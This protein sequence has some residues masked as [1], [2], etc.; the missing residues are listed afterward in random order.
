MQWDGR[1]FDPVHQTQ[2]WS[3]LDGPWIKFG[4]F[5]RAMDFFGN[6][7]LWII[8]APGHMPGNLCAAAHVGEDKWILLGSDCCHSRFVFLVADKCAGR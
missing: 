6:G 4:A 2:K 5:D 3:E 8:Q 7:S 1:Y